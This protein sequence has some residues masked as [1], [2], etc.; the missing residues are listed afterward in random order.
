MKNILLITSDQQHYMTLGINNPQIKTPNLDR[1]CKMGMTFDRAYCPNPTCTPTR[2]SIISGTYPSQHGAWT[3]GTK[4]PENTLTI[5]DILQDYDYETCLIGKAHFQPLAETEQYSSLESYPIMQNL[6]FWKDYDLP[7]YGFKTFELLRNHTTEA[8]VGQHYAIWL[9]EKG[10]ND[11]R[12]YFLTPTGNMDDTHYK[13]LEKIV[14]ENDNILGT[15]RTWGKWNIPREAH[16]N[17]WISERTNHYLEEYKKEDKPFFMWASFPDPHPEYFAPEPYASM[18]DPASL[19]LKLLA[20][21]EHQNSTPL[22]QKTQELNPDYS[23]YRESEWDIH[24]CHS[25]LQEEEELRKDVAVY[26]GMVTYMDEHIG[27]ILDKLEELE[28]VEDTLVVFT[29]DHGHYF[30]QH[31]LIR[32]G[33]FHYED[34][35][36]VPLIAAC[37]GSIPTNARS[38][39]LQSLV[40]LTPTFLSALGTEV[41][42]SMTGVNQWPVWNGA[43]NNIRDWIICEN[44]HERNNLNMRTYVDNRYKLTVYQKHKFGELYDLQIDPDELN[45]LWDD[46]NS[47]SLKMELYE[48]YIDAELEKEQVS[49]PRI[50]QA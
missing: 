32:K 48:K 16:Y 15:E 4:L 46:P 35:I 13:R 26:Y 42:I 20:A 39:S 34:G 37:P 41:P 11:W 36:K 27:R 24:G 50:K 28:M 1:L 44:R 49:M 3:L 18:Y 22:I 30:G 29:T 43:I 25:H 45:N 19:D 2:A 40:D 8:H 31:G 17:E 47:Q 10:F 7:F 14:N 12:D 21:G 23:E 5:G 6:D 38:N 33:P 9:E